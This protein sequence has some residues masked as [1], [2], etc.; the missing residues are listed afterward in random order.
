MIC[1]SIRLR[2]LCSR[3]QRG[4]LTQTELAD[5]LHDLIRAAEHLER[6]PELDVSPTTVDLPLVVALCRQLLSRRVTQFRRSHIDTLAATVLALAARGK[7][8]P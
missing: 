4:E 8:A 6:P 1:L 7:G 5:E 3:A 2:L